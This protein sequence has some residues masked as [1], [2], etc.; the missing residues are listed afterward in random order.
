MS[1]A[2]D[3]GAA[4]VQLLAAL[5]DYASGQTSGQQVLEALGE[6]RVLVPVVALLEEVEI[7]DDGLPR[8]KQSAMATVLIEQPGGERALLAFT[9]LPSLTEWRADARPVPVMA[10]AAAQSALAE[11]ASALLVDVAGP[12]PFVVTGPELVRLAGQRHLPTDQTAADRTSAL[13]RELVRVVGRPDG[14]LDAR[15]VDT[16]LVDEGTSARLVVTVDPQLDPV[17]YESLL[18]TITTGLAE[19]VELRALL[20]NGLALTVVGPDAKFADSE[21]LFDQR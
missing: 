10:A 18:A 7:G 1:F 13:S 19:S 9:S 20:P 8:D 6:S 11:G 14:L 3:D 4:P 21:S 2:D 15:L 5:A 16:L 17:A 12:T